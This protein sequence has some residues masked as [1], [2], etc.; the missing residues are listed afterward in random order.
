MILVDGKNRDWE[1]EVLSLFPIPLYTSS[2]IYF[3]EDLKDLGLGNVLDGLAGDK[4]DAILAHAGTLAR[5]K[6]EL[7]FHFLFGLRPLLGLL[8]LED[9]EN[10]VKVV[11]DIF[12][13]KGL[14]PAR[15]FILKRDQHPDFVRYWGTGVSLREG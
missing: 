12:D 4:R 6:P 5:I 10:W 8:E 7:A 15:E 13:A 3:E 1:G 14:N 2:H 9:L 11:L